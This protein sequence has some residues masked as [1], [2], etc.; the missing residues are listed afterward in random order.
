MRSSAQTKANERPA[1]RYSKLTR[2]PPFSV[3]S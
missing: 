2:F 3:V 1:S